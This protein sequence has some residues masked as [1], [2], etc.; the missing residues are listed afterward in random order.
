MRRRVARR[1]RPLRPAPGLAAAVR[2][3]SVGVT[4]EGVWAHRESG[5]WVGGTAA[6]PRRPVDAPV[7]VDP[8]RLHQEPV[9]VVLPVVSVHLLSAR[10][11]A[12]LAFTNIRGVKET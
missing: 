3:T 6:E 4:G 10:Q 2:S 5:R 12:N 11:R 9:Q 8:A 1:A 7:R